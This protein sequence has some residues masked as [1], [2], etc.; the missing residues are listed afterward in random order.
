MTQLLPTTEQ[1]LPEQVNN[2]SSKNPV[3]II[4][5]TTGS[6][7]T[8]TAASRISERVFR[9]EDLTELD[10]REVYLWIVLGRLQEAHDA[11]DIAAAAKLEAAFNKRLKGYERAVEEAA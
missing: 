7:V 5:D 3:S 9:R 4:I 8:G 2:S 10:R 1:K 11:G 6:A